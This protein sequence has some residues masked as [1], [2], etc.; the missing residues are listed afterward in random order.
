M[1]FT[2]TSIIH[3]TVILSVATAPIEIATTPSVT[4]PSLSTSIIHLV[5]GVV[6]TDIAVAIVV[7][8]TTTPFIFVVPVT[9]IIYVVSS[10]VYGKKPEKRESS[11]IKMEDTANQ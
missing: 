11:D 4:A 7:I 5:V 1:N 6:A 2:N 9:V 8:T 10:P 3:V